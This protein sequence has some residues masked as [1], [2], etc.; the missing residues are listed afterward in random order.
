M[1]VRPALGVDCH[2]NITS[3]NILKELNDMF[4]TDLGR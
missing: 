3:I 4:E 2:V 1:L